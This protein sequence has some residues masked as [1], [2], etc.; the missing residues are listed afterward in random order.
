M[1]SGINFLDLTPVNSNGSSPRE[2]GSEPAE[3]ASATPGWRAAEKRG[4][5]RAPFREPLKL[6]VVD[7]AAAALLAVDELV[8]EQAEREIDRTGRLHP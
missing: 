1:D 2:A 8:V 7:L 6:E 4:Y 3:Q 5:P